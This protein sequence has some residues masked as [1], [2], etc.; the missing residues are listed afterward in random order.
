MR[1]P[2]GKE[3]EYYEKILKRIK[4][5]KIPNREKIEHIEEIALLTATVCTHLLWIIIIT[6]VD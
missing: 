5:A 2:K 1:F 6:F 3:A 4:D